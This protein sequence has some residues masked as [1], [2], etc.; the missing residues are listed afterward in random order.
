MEGEDIN[1]NSISITVKFSGRSIPISVSLDSTI[2][3]F[4]S[5]LQPLTNVLPRGQKLIFKGK[6]LVDSMTLKESEVT[7]GAKVM[8]MSSQGLHQGD[9]PI[10]KDAKT[11]PI[12]RANL[13]NKMVNQKTEF[14]IDK[15]CL[16]RWKVTG[17]I[18][19]AECNLK[20]LPDQVWACGPSTRVLDISNNLIQD[21]PTKIGCMSSLQKLFLNGNSMSDES[22]YWEGLTSLKHLTVLS[23]SQNHL[24]VLPSELG[25]LSSLKHLN[26]SNNKLN[27]LPVEIGLLIQL[28]VLKANNNRMCT[29]PTSIG[30]CNSLVEVN[31]SSNLLTEL[32]ESFGNLHNLKALYLGNNGLKSLPSGLF[33]MCLQLSTLDLHNAEITMDILRQFEG[34]EDFDER[35]RSKHQKQLDFRAVSS[36]EFDEGADKN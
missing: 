1:C 29:I 21:L 36:A 3:D 23:L 35:R 25:A 10:L 12:S 7:N 26:I 19:L 9:G 34:W 18:A 20:V 22:I 5:L 32:P 27:C 8:L 31:L 14:S 30:E 13:A 17:V 11:R 28:E 16:D 2:K 4:K 15:N 6:L 33:K 24:T